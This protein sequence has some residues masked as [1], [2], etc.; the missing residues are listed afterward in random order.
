[1][2]GCCTVPIADTERF[3]GRLARLHRVRF[4]LFGF[5]STQR[6]LIAGI[7]QAGLAGSVLFEIG[8]GA[9]YLHQEL[10]KAG[11]SRAT[12]IDLSEPMLAEA[13]ALAQSAGLAERTDYRHGDFVD[14]ADGLDDADITI[15]DKVVCCYPDVDRLVSRS[16][17][18]TKKVYALTYPR[19]RALTRIGVGIAAYMLRRLRSNF[20]PYVHDPKKIE[21]NIV[22]RGFQKAFAR[23]TLA[24][25]TEVYT[26]VPT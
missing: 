3:F 16:L 12:G 11:A 22:S 20:R 14:L 13:R 15:L 10:L 9:G 2:M 26:R 6:D 19:D 17:E 18:K 8:C 25:T 1:M 21:A 7:R 4:K 5:E 24:W 23:H